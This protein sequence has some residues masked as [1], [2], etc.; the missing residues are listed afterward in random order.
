[1]SMVFH[2]KSLAAGRWRSF[3][4]V[5][6]LGNVGSEVSRAARWQAKDGRLYEGAVH[7]AFELLDLTIGD[8]R[9]HGR[10]KELAHRVHQHCIHG[11][12]HCSRSDGQRRA[13]DRSRGGSAAMDRQ[14]RDQELPKEF[15]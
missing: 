2:H 11:A 9:W 4:L 7:R 8:P 14:F 1:M 12:R 15:A 6:Q 13:I 5:E 10:R 3:S